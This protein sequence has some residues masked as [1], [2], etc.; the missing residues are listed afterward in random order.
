MA[1]DARPKLS[2]IMKELAGA[3]LRDPQS[4]PSSEAAHAALLLTHVAWNRALGQPLPEAQYRPMLEELEQTNPELWNELADNDVERMVARLMALKQAPYPQDERVIQVCGMRGGNVHV[5][6]YE[7][8]DV[9][10]A[11]RIATEHLARALELVM[12]GDEADAV[13]HLCRT[14]GMSREEARR[15]VD[16]LR[17]VLRGPKR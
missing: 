8:Q 10:D 9:R 12:S 15:Q 16:K 2:E 13:R 3:V 11:D 14:A 5:E 1:K 17:D 6:W 4:V 7:G